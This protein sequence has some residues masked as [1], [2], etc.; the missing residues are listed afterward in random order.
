MKPRKEMNVKQNVNGYIRHEF[1]TLNDVETSMMENFKHTYL[2][3]T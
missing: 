2:F 3:E 1:L